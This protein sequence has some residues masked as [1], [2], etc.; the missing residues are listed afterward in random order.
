M[1]L[2]SK[3]MFADALAMPNNTEAICTNWFD[4]TTSKYSDWVNSPIPI[5]VVFTCNTVPSAGTSIQIEF[6][7]HS[8]TTITSG[9]LLLTTRA[10]P[11][12]DLSA[13]PDDPGHWICCVPIISILSSIQSADVDRYWGPVLKGSGDVSSGAVDGFLWMGANPPIPVARPTASN[14]TKPA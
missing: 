7:Q 4:R 14:I 12:A 11:I 3:H 10:I 5:W 8:T 9:D 13:S 6:Y 1:I 2:D